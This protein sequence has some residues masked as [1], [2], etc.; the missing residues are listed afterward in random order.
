M[1]HTYVCVCPCVHWDSVWLGIER[2]T[3]QAERES[4]QELPKSMKSSFHLGTKIMILL[5]TKVSKEG[6]KSR[7]GR[8]G[9]QM[10]GAE[11]EVRPCSVLTHVTLHC[12]LL[13][14]R[15]Q[16]I[17]SSKRS[18][19]VLVKTGSMSYSLSTSRENYFPNMMT[20][21][22][23]APTPVLLPGKS[24]DRGAWWAAVYGVTKSRTQLSNFTFTFHFHALEKEMATHSSVLAWRIP[25][26]GEP[27]GLPSM[28]WHRVGN[29]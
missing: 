21:L 8:E 9:K 6:R 29:D 11:M 15:F 24:M 7:R 5:G 28:G 23:M 19:T 1:C 17:S 27:G 3:I 26:T 12:V 18:A 20:C 25:G 13:Q 10:G 16:N 14:E 22:Q 2:C 4:E